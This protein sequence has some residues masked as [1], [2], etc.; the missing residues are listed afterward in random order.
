MTTK[1]TQCHD[2]LV[3]KLEFYRGKGM[4]AVPVDVA[5]VAEIIKWL[6]PIKRARSPRPLP[7]NPTEKP[8]ETT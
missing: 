5:E 1:R 4:L 3:A 8:N 7:E 2:R 6:T